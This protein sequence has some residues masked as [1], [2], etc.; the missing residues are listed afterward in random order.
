LGLSPAVASFGGSLYADVVWTRASIGLEAQGDLPASKRIASASSVTVWLVSG[1][2]VPCLR[3]APV[4]V[5]ALAV[6][7]RLDATASGVLSQ[8]ER[9]GLYVGVGARVGFMIP[10]AAHL[11]VRGEA[12]IVGDLDRATVQV[13]ITDVWPAPAVA[14]TFALGALASF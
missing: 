13:G 4:D 5:C 8:T 7:G 9:A 3:F 10:L 12:D 2:L 14:G 11:A 6:V 1:A